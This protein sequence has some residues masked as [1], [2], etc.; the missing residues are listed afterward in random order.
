VRATH[1]RLYGYAMPSENVEIVSIRLR[2]LASRGRPE[3]PEVGV[4]AKGEPVEYRKVLFE[5]GEEYTPVFRRADLPAHF[6][7]E[8]A[9]IIE[10]KDSTTVVPPGM[11]FSV[12]GYGDIVIFK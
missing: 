4:E 5:E 11:W 10:A 3:P 8:G 6:E 2:A 1:S 12:D 9:A 7:R